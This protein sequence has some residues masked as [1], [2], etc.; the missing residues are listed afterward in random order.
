MAAK[1]HDQ[2]PPLALF[3]VAPIQCIDQKFSALSWIISCG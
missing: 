1:L 2:A 3:I